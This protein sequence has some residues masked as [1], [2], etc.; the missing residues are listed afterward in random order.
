MVDWSTLFS[1]AAVAAIGAVGH[2]LLKRF[3]GIEEGQRAINRHIEETNKSVVDLGARVERVE[4]WRE[5]HER[6]VETVQRAHELTRE[7]CRDGHRRDL[8]AMRDEL[9][10]LRSGPR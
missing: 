10:L 6:L 5:N 1:G 4:T 7:Q 3:D 9:R 2:M 8:D